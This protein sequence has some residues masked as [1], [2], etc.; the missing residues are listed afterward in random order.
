MAYNSEILCDAEC[1]GI[2]IFQS[3][4]YVSYEVRISVYSMGGI[5]IKDIRICKIKLRGFFVDKDGILITGYPDN[6]NVMSISRFLLE[7][8]CLDYFDSDDS[9]GAKFINVNFISVINDEIYFSDTTCIRQ[10]TKTG[11]V[12]KKWG[13]QQNMLILCF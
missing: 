3:Q 6:C 7:G 13:R 5:K 2:S 8:E 11:K 9:D 1:C 4:I 12:I 10:C